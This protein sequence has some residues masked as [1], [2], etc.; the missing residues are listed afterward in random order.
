MRGSSK[1]ENL[2]PWTKLN[3]ISYTLSVG[4]QKTKN[5]K[6]NQ[7]KWAVGGL[8]ASIKYKRGARSMVKSCGWPHRLIL[9]AFL[10]YL[11]TIITM[12]EKKKISSY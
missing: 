3:Q 7:P 1:N 10:F 4:P 5:A 6:T 2:A 8:S 12:S 9:F 11:I